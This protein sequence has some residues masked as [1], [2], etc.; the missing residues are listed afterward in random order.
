MRE[1]DYPAIDA[2]D[3]AAVDAYFA[4]LLTPD[5]AALIG[6][7]AANAAA[8]FPVHDVSATQGQLL[9]LLIQ[10]TGA[11]RVLEIGTLGGYSTIHM[12]RALPRGG[13]IVTI[14]LNSA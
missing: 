2:A 7:L 9:A 1:P 3:W 13:V 14:E 12:A 4:G 6:A 5:D 10:I 8:G 11:T